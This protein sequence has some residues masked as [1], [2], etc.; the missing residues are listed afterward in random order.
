MK[1]NDLIKVPNFGEP[2]QI[3]PTQT[4]FKSLWERYEDYRED[5]ELTPPTVTTG[6]DTLDKCVKFN[7]FTILGG[8][9][10][11]GKTSLCLNIAL[12]RAKKGLDTIFYSLEMPVYTLVNRIICNVC[13]TDYLHA[14]ECWDIFK[15]KPDI[16]TAMQHIYFVGGKDMITGEQQQFDTSEKSELVTTINK[17]KEQK[18]ETTDLLIIIDSLHLLPSDTADLRAATNENVVKIR[19]LTDTYHLNSIVIGQSK[20]TDKPLSSIVDIWDKNKG[21]HDTTQLMGQLRESSMIEF[22]VDCLYYI[23]NDSRPPTIDTTTKWL[24]AIKNRIADTDNNDTAIT[25]FEFKGC[26][27]RFI[28]KQIKVSELTELPQLPQNDEGQQGKSAETSQNNKPKKPKQ[29]IK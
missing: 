7:G 9:P 3:T 19:N 14:R 1:Q 15:Q 29:T 22:C 12:N 23:L 11:S 20:R 27:Y 4:G 8:A 18:Q 6:F 21:V 13:N 16:I 26:Y 5:M 2:V 17:I 24:C 28:D 25:G 10:R